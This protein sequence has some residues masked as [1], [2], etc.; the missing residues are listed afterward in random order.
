MK[1]IVFEDWMKD[2][3]ETTGRFRFILDQ[4]DV[5][6]LKRGKRAPARASRAGKKRGRAS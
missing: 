2:E 3:V 1:T 4:F 6:R 5:S